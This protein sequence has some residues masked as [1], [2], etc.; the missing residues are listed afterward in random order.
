MVKKRE[1]G[2]RLYFLLCLSFYILIIFIFVYFGFYASQYF[3]WQ[4]D[5]YNLI[6]PFV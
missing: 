2:S 4:V 1:L 3:M 5:V 6:Q